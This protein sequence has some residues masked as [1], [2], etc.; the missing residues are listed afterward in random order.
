[1]KRKLLAPISIVLLFSAI[2][3]WSFWDDILNIE[4]ASQVLYTEPAFFADYQYDRK[5]MIR[6]ELSDSKSILIKVSSGK[7]VYRY[8]AAARKFSYEDDKI[9]DAA[10]GEIKI[11]EATIKSPSESTPQAYGKHT[12]NL[13]DNSTFTKT[14]IVTSN[15]FSIPPIGVL[16]NLGGSGRITGVRYF[17]VLSSNR[18]KIGKTLRIKRLEMESSPY[19]CWSSDDEF[20]IVSN[21][22]YSTLAVFDIADIDKIKIGQAKN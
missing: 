8:E 9:W 1:M 15:G 18:E 20:V 2:L 7:G 10:R 4:Y 12:L 5:L 6:T 14:A 17:E 22:G 19:I 21:A 13:E 16:P 3:A 11:C